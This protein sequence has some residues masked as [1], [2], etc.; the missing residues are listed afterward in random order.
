MKQTI[1]I[2]QIRIQMAGTRGHT[3]EAIAAAIARHVAERSGRSVPT[4]I[5][6]QL[7]ARLT[8]KRG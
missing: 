5:Q 7:A 1:R 2:K 8:Q 6:A 3:N 4:S